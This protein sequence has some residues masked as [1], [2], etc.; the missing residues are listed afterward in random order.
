M[1]N[2]LKTLVLKALPAVLA[3]QVL[4]LAA[5]ASPYHTDFFDQL[6]ESFVY[7]PNAC[8]DVA[9]GQDTRTDIVNTNN[10]QGQSFTNS[11]HGGFGFKG[12]NI[13]GG[14]SRSRT[15][16]QNNT[17]GHNYTVSTV[18]TGKDCNVNQTVLGNV[19]MNHDQQITNRMWIESQERLGMRQIS[20]QGTLS[21]MGMLFNL[22]R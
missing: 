14:G 21:Y 12:F 4:P 7:S 6:N 22:R 15:T 17:Y 2:C 1:P 18:R 8:R 11:G 20:V 9:L 19:M 13:G 10:E 3:C 16:W 5:E